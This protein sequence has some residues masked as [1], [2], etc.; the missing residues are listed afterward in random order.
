MVIIGL[1]CSFPLLFSQF[2]HLPASPRAAPLMV[3]AATASVSGT[4]QSP[5]TPRNAWLAATSTWKA[6]AWTPAHP[7]T[8][9]LRGGDVWPSASARSCTTNARMPGSRAVTLSTTMNV[10]TS[11]HRGTSWIPASKYKC[12][13]VKKAGSCFWT[14]LSS[15]SDTGFVFSVKTKKVSGLG[16]PVMITWSTLIWFVN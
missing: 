14:V 3:S 10:F 13:Q 11:A 1:R 6:D 2:V 8:T 9:A 15:L 7:V 5:T 16:E 4:A 12:L